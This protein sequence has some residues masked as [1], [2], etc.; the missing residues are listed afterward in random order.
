MK[1]ASAATLWT[2]STAHSYLQLFPTPTSNCNNLNPLPSPAYPLTCDPSPP[3][4]LQ[5][6]KWNGIPSYS[7]SPNPA[8][9]QTSPPISFHLALPRLA[10][11]RLTPPLAK[12]AGDSSAGA[13]RTLG[14]PP[15]SPTAVAGPRAAAKHVGRPAGGRRAA[16]GGPKRIRAGPGRLDLFVPPVGLNRRRG[17]AGQRTLLPAL[18]AW[19]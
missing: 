10:P 5:A 18:A 11:P 3:T 8:L 12:T 6:P 2:V 17:Q 14:R 16:V 1:K 15:V 13:I 4:L 19:V 9:P 7:T